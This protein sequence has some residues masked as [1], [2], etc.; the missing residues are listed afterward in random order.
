M[1]GFRSVGY[2]VERTDE[3]HIG[4]LIRQVLCPIN[5]ERCRLLGVK[6]DFSPD[7]WREYPSDGYWCG[8]IRDDS[9]GIKLQLTYRSEALEDNSVRLGMIWDRP[10]IKSKFFPKREVNSLISR[11]Q[12]AIEKEFRADGLNY[13]QEY[14]Y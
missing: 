5:V 11:W 3:A 1:A 6:V 8:F 13:K 9:S 12:S 4:Y 2:K 7:K 10:G 14:Q